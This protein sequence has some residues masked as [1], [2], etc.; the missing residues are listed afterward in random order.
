M[1]AC[2]SSG[3]RI[4]IWTL[5]LSTGVFERLTAD[6]RD[7]DDPVWTADSKSISFWSDRGGR[8]AFYRRTVGDSAE[9]M[10]F[11]APETSPLKWL[12]GL[13]RD[14]QTLLFHNG[15][16]IFSLAMTGTAK[17]VKL[18]EGAVPGTE[19][20][21]FSPDGRW[22]AYNGAAS[23]D[24]PPEVRLVSFP[25][26]DGRKQLST[27]GGAV[28][29]W[30]GDG[31]ELFYLTP[32]GKMMSIAVTPGATRTFGAPTPLFQTPLRNPKPHLDEYAV[33]ADGQRFLILVPTPDAV[34]IPATVILDWMALLR[35]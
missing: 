5:G 30:R 25:G 4:D 9:E 15:L 13:S 32:D 35:Y 26:A 1:H 33:A 23:I 2:H 20:A 16:Q 27:G 19:E 8:H 28:P 31:K 21:H 3:S 24:A 6:P 22:V 10:F 7:D 17:P 11:D 34:P 12:C 18:L 29:W 14:G